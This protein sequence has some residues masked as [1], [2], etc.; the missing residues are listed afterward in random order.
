ME[1]YE[2]LQKEFE[3]LEPRKKRSLKTKLKTKEV[4]GFDTETV[5]GYAR[6]ICS[7][8]KRFCFI[9]NIYQI[10]KFLTQ[11][12]YS[13]T[14]NFF[15]NVDF[16]FMAIIKHLP[17]TLIP[18]LYE[19]KAITFDDYFIRWLPKKGFEIRKNKQIYRYFDLY[20]FYHMSLNSA[21]IKYLN[22][23]K[24][25]IDIKNVED[26]FSDPKKKI[27]LLKY[28]MKDAVLTARLG[29]LLQSKLNQLGIDFSKPYSCGYI[30]MHYFYRD[31]PLH[32]FLKQEWELYAF[33]SY[34]GGR[35]EVIKR[36]YFDKVYQYDINSAYP[37]ALTKLIDVRNG[38]WIKSRDIPDFFYYG[39]LKVQVNEYEHDIL[40]PLPFRRKDGLVYFPNIQYP[41]IWY[42]A[43]P[44]FELAQKMGVEM[45]ILDGWFFLPKRFDYLF[46]DIKRLYEARKEAKKNDKAM[47]LTLKL[48]MN[49]LYG[50]FAERESKIKT[51]LIPF[52]GAQSV[53]IGDQTIYFKEIDMAGTL[54]NPVY[55]SYITSLTRKLLLE[56][57]INNLDHVLMFATDSILT[58]KP[59][60]QESD[61]LGKWK[62]EMQGEAVLIMSGVY[63]IRSDSEIKTRF[64]GFPIKGEYNFFD[65]LKNHANE[66]KIVFELEKAIKLG[67][68]VNFHRIYDLEDLCVFKTVEKGLDCFGDE[69]RDW[70]HSP[71]KFGD[72]LESQYDSTPRY[73]PQMEHWYGHN[74]LKGYAKYQWDWIKAIEFERFDNYYT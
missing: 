57:C 32:R 59:I 4:I 26:Y 17:Q 55:A 21:S 51:K 47:D 61:E 33:L 18:I 65:L 40:S 71:T 11:R 62:L 64:R 58:D 38:F 15:W 30:A 53:S 72:L 50:K 56:S 12:K 43:Y 68:V 20:Q 36:G 24:E 46:A 14:L 27:V 28:C 25:E 8:D 66:D 19:L 42:L 74:R 3:S 23:R 5:N 16:D 7:S 54:F 52:D 35:F 48:I 39:F 69:K 41:D 22:D 34:F 1:C 6:L 10:L 13:K 9:D 70:V 31:R 37:Y 45:D 29:S 60:L 73:E 49:S 63:S 67:E 44:E 2:K